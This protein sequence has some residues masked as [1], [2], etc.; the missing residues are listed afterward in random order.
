MVWRTGILVVLWLVVCSMGCDD[1]DGESSD[2]CRF[3]PE[4][5]KG[6]PGGLCD[7]DR[8]CDPDLFCCDDNKNCGDGMC[9][10]ECKDDRDCP[11]D[12]L[13]EHEM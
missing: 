1:D 5:C 11:E 2:I 10:A 4:N 9:T 7:D 6:G 13:C 3:E 8:D 12:M